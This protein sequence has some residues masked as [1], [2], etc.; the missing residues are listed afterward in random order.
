[1]VKQQCP[2]RPNKYDNTKRNLNNIF[3]NEN[4]KT[5]LRQKFQIS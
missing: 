1:M 5:Y 2:L 4:S 3:N